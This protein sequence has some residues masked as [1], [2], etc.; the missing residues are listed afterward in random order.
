MMGAEGLTD[1]SKVAILNA[2]YMAEKLKNHY[3]VSTH[4]TF[5][6]TSIFLEVC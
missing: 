3:K 4:L 1:A 5:F 6:C 2:N